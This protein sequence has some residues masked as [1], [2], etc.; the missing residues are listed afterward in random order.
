IEELRIKFWKRTHIFIL[1]LSR[2]ETHF[3]TRCI[4]LSENFGLHHQLV[5]LPLEMRY[6]DAIQFSCS[7]HPYSSFKVAK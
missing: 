1:Q 2:W 4:L 6:N 7:Q 5:S 3:F